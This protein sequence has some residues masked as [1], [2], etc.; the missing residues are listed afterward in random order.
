MQ[1]WVFLLHTV[2]FSLGSDIGQRALTPL[3]IPSLAQ[4]ESL[5]HLSV[6]D[7]KSHWAVQHGPWL[8]LQTNTNCGCQEKA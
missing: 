8:G 5:R 6:L 1:T 4:S 3:H 2:K 7:L